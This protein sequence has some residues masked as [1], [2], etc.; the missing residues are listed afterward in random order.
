ML[1]G[2]VV[3]E[4]FQTASSL[5]PDVATEGGCELLTGLMRLE[6]IPPPVLAI[7]GPAQQ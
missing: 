7:T 5:R 2:T 1:S 6:V 3:S 4:P